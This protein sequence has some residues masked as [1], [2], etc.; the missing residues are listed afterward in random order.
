MEHTDIYIDLER[1]QNVDVGEAT[2]KLI[3]VETQ[4]QALN[5]NSMDINAN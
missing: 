1:T 2:A 4:I 3:A 5:E